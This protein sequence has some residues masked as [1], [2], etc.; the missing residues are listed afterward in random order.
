MTDLEGSGSCGLHGGL[1]EETTASP[2]PDGK[3]QGRFRE[4][5]TA[6]PAPD[7]APYMHAPSTLRAAPQ[8]AASPSPDG[9][10]EKI[11]PSAPCLRV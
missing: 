6:S 11:N 3:V 5:T 9:H 8:D 1:A 4:E 7:E 10:A 2:A